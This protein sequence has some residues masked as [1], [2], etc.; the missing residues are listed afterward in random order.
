MTECADL[1]IALRSARDGNY[2]VELRSMLPD[3][4]AD[5]RSLGEAYFDLAQL[6]QLSWDMPSY[7]RFLT[8]SLLK[9][10][11]IRAGLSSARSTAQ[12]KELPLRIRLVIDQS[13]Q[14]LHSLHWETLLDIR[15]NSYLFA[16]EQVLFS[17]YLSSPDWQPIHLGP[18]GAPTALVVVASPN[19]LAEYDLPALDVNEELT[20]ARTCMKGVEIVELAS[21]GVATLGNLAG[22]LRDHRVDVL[23]LVCHGSMVDGESLLWFE[24]PTG[25][26]VHE[27]GDDLVANLKELRQRPRLVVLI[28]CQSAG[29]ATESNTDGKSMLAALGPRL[30]GAGIPAV[31][32]MQGNV[33]LPTIGQFM[34]V[35]FRELLRSGQ[36]DHA[37]AVARGAVRNRPDF[38]MPVLFMRSKSGRIWADSKSPPIEPPIDSH[39]EETRPVTGHPFELAPTPPSTKATNTTSKWMLIALAILAVTLGS[40]FVYLRTRTPVSPV[41]DNLQAGA[42]ENPKLVSPPPQSVNGSTSSPQTQRAASPTASNSI[43][44]SGS[45]G[46]T[47]TGAPSPS[48]PTPFWAVQVNPSTPRLPSFGAAF[49]IRVTYNL[50]GQRGS[51][52]PYITN[53]SDTNCK[54]KIG[55]GNRDKQSIPVTQDSGFAD[56]REQWTHKSE[57]PEAASILVGAALSGTSLDGA[58][59]FPIPR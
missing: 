16:G 5:V 26:V 2:A 44:P 41:Q 54:E 50:K 28:S 56:L 15:D 4:D 53:Y 23:Y 36:I 8:D 39:V 10:P 35:F 46:T 30:T 59:C 38:W 11:E 37:M 20:R 1:E 24:D 3:S 32:A 34:P 45:A 6:H 57:E 33:S 27:R 7:A 51:I 58:Q 29:R 12:V 52:H 13:A 55:S 42:Q 48:P 14:D 21:G 17:R 9:D 18:A 43:T 49:S 25:A 47:L 19:N 22:H 40:V 31:I